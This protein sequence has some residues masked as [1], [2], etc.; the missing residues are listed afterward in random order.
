MGDHFAAVVAAK[1]GCRINCGK[2]KQG[3]L[4]ARFY[5]WVGK[6][7]RLLANATGGGVA[8]PN[9]IPNHHPR[10]PAANPN[11]IPGC[12]SER[13][14]QSSSAVTGCQRL[15][16]P[17]GASTP[18]WER[19]S[20]RFTSSARPSFPL[21]T[22]ASTSTLS[23]GTLLSSCAHVWLAIGGGDKA[24]EL[25]ITL[26]TGVNYWTA[27]PRRQHCWGAGLFTPLLSLNLI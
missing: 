22:S 23:A 3:M 1:E 5:A 20:R 24:R 6:D 14:P 7:S 27:R 4:F 25:L 8:N 12:P 15:P 11:R 10:L 21:A 17:T 16:K 2:E 13:I 19:R 9:R 26:V 18:F